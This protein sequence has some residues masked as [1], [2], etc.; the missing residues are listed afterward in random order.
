MVAKF[1]CR[2]LFFM[3][4]IM[5]LAVSPSY[6]RVG[7]VQT[8]MLAWGNGKML[9]TPR[10]YFSLELER[11]KPHLGTRYKYKGPWDYDVKIPW[12]TDWDK[13]AERLLS[14]CKDLKEVAKRILQRRS[15]D[16]GVITAWNSETITEDL[17]ELGEAI[18]RDISQMYQDMEEWEIHSVSRDYETLRKILS[19]YSE[20]LS[21]KTFYY[22]IGD[23]VEKA[24]LDMVAELR[25]KDHLNYPDLSLIAIP[26]NLPAEFVLYIRGVVAFYQGDWGK[27][28]DYWMQVL[29]LPEAWRHYKSTWAAFMLGRSGAYID[30]ESAIYWLKKT[31][32]LVD[33]GYADSLGLAASSYLWQARAELARGRYVE[34]IEHYAE[35]Y[36]TGDV[37]ATTL[38]SWVIGQYFK[39]N[40]SFEDALANPITRKVITI[41]IGA[42]I[43]G[44]TY[45]NSRSIPDDQIIKWIEGLEDSWEEDSELA[46]LVAWKAF[47]VGRYDI[48]ERWYER[49]PDDAPLKL[50]LRAFLYLRE[51]KFDESRDILESM[52]E[53]I[54]EDDYTYFGWC[55]Y[56]GVPGCNSFSVLPG[57]I[58]GQ[59]ATIYLE[60]NRFIDALDLYLKGGYWRD[61]AY[62]AER[63]LKPDEL[64]EY[65]EGNMPSPI[66]QVNT[67]YHNYHMDHYKHYSYPGS[68]QS[69]VEWR[70]FKFRYILARRLCRLGRF[71][72]AGEYLPEV[73]HPELEKYLEGIEI[74]NNTKLTDAE[75]AEGFWQA[76]EVLRYKGM[77]LMGTEIGP[78]W[79]V[80]WGR[81]NPPSRIIDARGTPIQA[82]F[83]HSSAHER[84]RLKR[85]TAEITPYKRFHYRYKALDAY[86]KAIELMPD[87]TDET[88]KRICEA[89]SWMKYRDP[90]AVDRFYKALVRRCGK[91]EL[92]KEAYKKRW[93]PDV[94]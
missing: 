56:S 30:Q 89:G 85:H 83:F 49:C 51:G 71:D 10:L 58:V 54:P 31:R 84:G 62:L 60:Q 16:K 4:L 25:E 45:P 75:R 19:P 22:S 15:Y 93:F 34:A 79:T 46:D 35:Y 67:S 81:Y 1:L 92:G 76:A 70:W 43:S 9:T 14:W 8:S 86:W 13:E 40:D 94:W 66:V 38:L 32:E 7:E 87:N 73:L 11:V 52:L 37:G 63:I 23:D 61:A 82:G 41:Y 17:R 65:V 26:D 68:G 78:D 18:E 77:E 5:C 36:A 90:Q 2:S 47:D 20:H 28:R 64:I 59:L 50:W 29:E 42:S 88:A 3:L 53:V 27:A 55:T 33:A 72:E 44:L 57:R 12:V 48:A 91:T 39:N 6:A 69:Q 24:W 21:W 80:H 74:G